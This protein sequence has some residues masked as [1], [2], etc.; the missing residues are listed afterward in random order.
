MSQLK[1]TYFDISGGRGEP[2]RLAMILGN[3]EFDDFR[4]PFS[5]F[6]AIRKETPLGQV[7]TFEVNLQQVTQCNAIL[8]YVG[9]QAD[10]YPLDYFEALICDEILDIIEDATQKL[11]MT[12][13]LEGDALKRSREKLVKHSFIPALHL[14]VKRHEISQKLFMV[15]DRLSIADLKVFVWLNA[16]N[17]GHLDHI[18]TSLVKSESPSLNQHNKMVA[19]IPTINDYYQK[20]SS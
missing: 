9:K 15:G 5:D 19:E 12:F 7:P 11:V 20:L 16:L 3:I 8:R 10:L 4:F 1:L 14:L 18:P 6:A 2:I 13:G 17:A